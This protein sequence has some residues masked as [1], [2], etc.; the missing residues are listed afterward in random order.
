MDS[1]QGAATVILQFLRG[2]PLFE[3]ASPANVAT[4]AGASRLKVVPRG[5]FLFFQSDAANGAYLLRRGAIAIQLENLDGRELVINEMGP[6]E[7]FGELGIL[8]G[9]VRSAS[10]EAIVDSEVV[11]IPRA[12]FEDVLAREPALARRLLEITA[13]R[14]QNSAGR[15]EALAFHDAQQRVA[16][17]LVQLDALASESEK[18]YLI[19]SQEGLAQRTGLARQTVT[20]VLGGMRRRGWLLTGRGNIVLLNRRELSMIGQPV[21]SA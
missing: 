16:R 18:G 13:R 4:L 5:N 20:T 7:C 9:M 6:G 21:D 12:A 14:L 11:F 2:L 8:T 17:L 10:A 1:Q 3:E 15:E 19:L